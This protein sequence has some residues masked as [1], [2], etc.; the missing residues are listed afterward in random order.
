MV[1]LNQF[2]IIK[3]THE[4]N[5]KPAKKDRDDMVLPAAGHDPRLHEKLDTILA[6]LKRIWDVVGPLSAAVGRIT[7]SMDEYA[8][9]T[10]MDVSREVTPDRP[11]PPAA[12]P[13]TPLPPPPSKVILIQPTPDNS[14]KHHEPVV[15]LHPTPRRPDPEQTTTP[16]ISQKALVAYAASGPD[17]SESDVASV[18]PEPEASVPVA[19]GPSSQPPAHEEVEAAASVSESAPVTVPG[20]TSSLPQPATS[21]ALVASPSLQ[22]PG[23]GGVEAAASDMDTGG[24]LTTSPPPVELIAADIVPAASFPSSRPSPITHSPGPAPHTRSR[25]KTPTPLFPG[26]AAHTRSRS[27]TP[28]LLGP[29]TSQSRSGMRSRTPSPLPGTKR[30]ANSDQEEDGGSKKRRI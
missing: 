17:D 4:G 24:D 10:P 15:Q 11:Q 16:P 21:V 8:P 3:A 18:P 30:K 26:P 9:Q 23:D 14:Q 29:S 5:A 19:G 20:A 7:R 22:P 12:D 25:S 1:S 2:N 6:E 27:K 13:P 28:L